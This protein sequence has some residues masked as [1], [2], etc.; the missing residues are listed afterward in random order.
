MFVGEKKGSALNTKWQHENSKAIAKQGMYPFTSLLIWLFHFEI[1]MM[2]FFCTKHNS[3]SLMLPRKYPSDFSCFLIARA[4]VKVLI[5]RCS[6]S[7][8]SQSFSS[9][10]PELFSLAILSR[11]ILGSGFWRKFM[12]FFSASADF[13]S[14]CAFYFCITTIIWFSVLFWGEKSERH[15]QKKFP[16]SRV[17]V[18]KMLLNGKHFLVRCPREWLNKIS[19]EGGKEKRKITFLLNSN[20]GSFAVETEKENCGKNWEPSCREFLMKTRNFRWNNN[21]LGEVYTT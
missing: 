17:S 11:S 12:N 7:C 8:I 1:L 10:F 20:C 15:T 3:C 6:P 5:S 14:R 16:R 2:N 18:R 4:R 13:L 9:A 19:I 21:F